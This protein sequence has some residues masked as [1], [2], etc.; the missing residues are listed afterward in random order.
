MIWALVL[1]L[2]AASPAIPAPAEQEIV[3]NG[4]SACGPPFAKTYIAPMGEPVRT[5][6]FTDP[7]KLW[8]GRADAD[9]DGKLTLA[10]LQADSDRFFAVLDQ[11]RSG[12]IDP[13]EM[14][15]YE[16]VVAPEIKLYQRDQDK[17]TRT[18]KQR[19]AAKAAARER[20]DYEAP[21]GAGLWSSLNIPQPIVSADFDLNRGVSR[22]E[23][24]RAAANR[25][26]LLD[27]TG[28]GYLTLAT[29]AKS[30][31]QID[32]DACRAA[33]DKKRR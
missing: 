24:D 21:Y 20:A 19:K 23:L 14:A 30:P 15:R 33:A 22:A 11:D 25:W 3:V 7:M 32:I 8:F 26:P 29:L 16:N 31:A 13:D 12:E 28:R 17:G 2:Q 27:P 5:D 9:H 10:E 18:G 4:P 6:G 1:A